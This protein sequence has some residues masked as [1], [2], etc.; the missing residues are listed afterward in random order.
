MDGL[1]DRNAETL[2]ERNSAVALAAAP[3]NPAIYHAGSTASDTTQLRDYWEL[4][5][6]HLWLIIGLSLLVTMVVAIYLARKP[7]VFV[8]QALVQIDLEDLSPVR[9]SSK[10]NAVIVSNSANDPAYFNTQLRI[11]TSYGLLSRVAATLDLENNA[12]FLK[13]QTTRNNST[14]QNLLRTIGLGSKSDNKKADNAKQITQ[15]KSTSAK[16]LA[17]P[18]AQTDPAEAERYTPLVKELLENLQVEPVVEKRMGYGR[19]TTRL[20]EIKYKHPDP[21]LAAQIVNTM[22]DVLARFNLERKGE[23]SLSTGDFLQKRIAELQGQIRGGE[24]RLLSYAK[25]KE[26]LSLDGNQNTV[27][28]RLTGLNKQL[29]EAENERKLAESAYN[30]AR[31][32]GAASALAE[33]IVIR[34]MSELRTKLAELRQKRAQLLVDNTERWPEVTEINQQISALEKEMQQVI[35]R[36]SS[37]VLTNLETRYR[38]ANERE[39]AIRTAFKEQ[40][41]DT[42]T[43]NEAAV[44]YRIIQQ[45]IETNKSLLNDLLQSYKEN[46]VVLAGLHNN[47]AVI[48]Y[49]ITPDKPV[50]PNRL[51]GILLALL[52][53]LPCGVGLALALEYFNNTVRTL[54]EVERVLH[55]P[56]LAA[57]PTAKAGRERTAYPALLFNAP[58]RSPVN[59]AYRQLRTAVLLSTPRRAPKTMLITSAM[60]SE[61]KTT[62]SVN[63]A[64]SLAQTKAKVLIIDADLRRPRLH[65]IFGLNNRRGLSTYLSSEMSD[66]ELLGLLQSHEL[67]GL[68]VLTSG[69]VPP[70]PAELLGSE[71]M[72]R[73][74]DRLQTVYTHIILDSAPAASFTDAVLLSSMVDGLLLVVR[75]GNTPTAVVRRVRQLLL[76]ANANVIGAVL[77]QVNGH[78]FDYYYQNSYYSLDRQSDAEERDETEPSAPIIDAEVITEEEAE[79]AYNGKVWSATRA[80][81]AATAD[82]L[83]APAIATGIEHR[84]YSAPHPPTNGNGKKRRTKGTRRATPT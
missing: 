60:P 29:L 37:V 58:A 61:G 12:A 9:G 78:Q 74:L 38:Q 77:T 81:T 73:L 75:S 10:N 64:I 69:P 15:E 59:E 26:I 25:S 79:P 34:Q 84:R 33:E 40:R 51:R 45:E 16:E 32:P 57:I 8:A 47:V 3:V 13:P 14:W 35:G 66:D 39:Q 7:D 55:L 27:V 20:I 70:N 56:A 17:P 67:S 22:A 23:K 48:D 1:R 41:G 54:E 5:Q 52:F 83:T 6:K 2:A 80:D 49:A 43:Q 31:E 76:G 53:S 36:A 21:L 24:E 28:D 11:L 65:T 68:T 18:T 19:D 4:V 72:R 62:S 46:D 82:D 71:Q 42:L 63:L 30:A 50:G 44:N